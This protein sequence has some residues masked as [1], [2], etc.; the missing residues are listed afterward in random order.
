MRL[1]IILALSF[2]SVF[3]HAQQSTIKGIVSCNGKPVEFAHIWI[4]NTNTGTTTGINGKFEITN[5]DKGSYKLNISCLGY[6]KDS[7]EIHLGSAETKSIQIKLKEEELNLDEVVVTGTLK[8]TYIS[9]SPV[10]I[11]IITPKLFEKNPSPTIFE[12]LNMVNGVRPQMQCNVCNT[13]DIH[14][15]GMEG[16]YTMVMI[17]GMPIVS[18]LGSVYGLMGIPNSIIQ[19]V[20]IQKGP[21]STLYGS[22][23]V[24]GL[25]NIITKSA[26]N[27]PVFSID[28]FGTSYSE[29][30]GDASVKYKA[31][32]KISGIFSG[33]IFHFDKKWDV[34]N[35]HFTDVT[36]QKR[37]AAFNKFTYQ[38][39]SGKTSH[40]ALRY[41]YEDRWGGETNWTPNYRGSD[42]IYGESIYTNRFELIGSSPLSFLG[43]NTQ[44][45]YSVNRHV[46][47][48]AYGT[49]PF[50]AEQFIGFGQI[51]KNII[52]KRHD[53]MMGMAIRYTF[54][55]D[56]TV[57]TQNE[58]TDGNI[59]NQPTITYLPGFFIQDEY[60]A[61]EKDKILAGM[62]YDYNSH[63]GNIFSPRINW[64]HTFNDFNT[65]RFGIGNGYRVVNLFSEDH[66]AFNGAREVVITE[67][68]RPEQSWNANLNYSTFISVKNGFLSIDGNLF[69][70]YFS[71]KIVADYFTDHNKVIFENLH[72]HGINR[73]AGIQIHGTFG[74]HIKMLAGLTY[75]DVYL[76]EKD[77]LNNEIISRQVQTPPLTANFVAGYNFLKLKMNID[78]SSN[79][80]SPM[81]LPVLPN[82]FRPD[83]SPWFCLMNIQI[84]KEIKTKW[85]IY[86]GVKNLLNFMPQNPI[87]RPFDPFDRNVNDPKN[88]PNGYT[89]DPGYNYAPVQG[90]R[91]FAGIRY[92]FN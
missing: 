24:G 79:I 30:N 92:K 81:L 3:C 32:K 49:T 28:I 66:A 21:A 7:I 57:I 15:N 89:F 68:L 54:Y 91:G 48:S 63:H 27:A 12:S 59:F 67:N 88:N 16:P 9:E 62:R 39:K 17:D 85:Q 58:N 19:R 44:L 52:K 14:I 4:K 80:Y 61:S 37:Y 25:I 60:I 53:L 77:S 35:D 2:L 33:N 84:T 34:N 13:G 65:L 20:E 45:L 50:L 90:I 46:Q 78:I 10:A 69:Y 5:L 82:D 47:N 36:L 83:H 22:E 75:T 76:K 6:L 8:E 41:Y 26:V 18:A 38:H 31:G 73:G 51:T 72:G 87:M 74:K 11:E 40:L 29:F 86:G 43:S 23:A 56:N 55:D 1:R 70:T 71:N 64:K 42:S